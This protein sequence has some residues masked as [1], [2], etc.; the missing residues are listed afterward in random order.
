MSDWVPRMGKA[1]ERALSVHPWQRRVAPA[2]GRSSETPGGDHQGIATRI[3]GD[4]GQ[5]P[6]RVIRL[7]RA[8]GAEVPKAT[9]TMSQRTESA[10][11]G[12]SSLRTS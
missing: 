3:R 11:G 7:S 4:F 10:G 1:V 9:G 12:C 6:S 5:C 8:A 2:G